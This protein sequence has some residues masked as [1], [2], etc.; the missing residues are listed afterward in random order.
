MP[1]QPRTLKLCYICGQTF[2]TPEDRRA[3]MTAEHP[4]MRLAWRGRN[5][6]LIDAQGSERVVTKAER[7]KLRKPAPVGSTTPAEG[8]PD[9]G[10][11]PGT[12]PVV[13]PSRARPFVVQPAPRITPG[14]RAEI[15]RAS[16]ADAFTSRM[17]A[18]VIRQLSVA[19]S[20]MDGAGPAGELTQIQSAQI[21]SLLYDSTIDL[22]VARFG[23]SVGRFKLALAVLIILAAKGRVHAEAIAARIRERQARAEAEWAAYGQEAAAEADRVAY[24]PVEPVA[25]ADNGVSRETVSLDP[26]ADL[27]ARQAR[28]RESS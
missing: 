5:P 26:I 4:G 22:I 6:I 15:D 2:P 9:G 1:S 11:V 28:A 19:I 8:P 18:D 3:H 7:D 21:A 16:V 14:V 25:S 20:E 13:E 10:G 24:A 27:A 23:G 12:P 17:L